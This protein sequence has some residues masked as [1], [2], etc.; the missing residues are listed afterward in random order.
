MLKDVINKQV[1]IIIILFFP[2]LSTSMKTYI[3]QEN[4]HNLSFYSVTIHALELNSLWNF[5]MIIL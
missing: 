5:S 1:K 4:I 3:G 2:H